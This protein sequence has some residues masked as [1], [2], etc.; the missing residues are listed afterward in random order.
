M[1]RFWQDV[2][3]APV[4]GG[5]QVV[6]D[7]RPLRTQGGAQQV[8]PSGALAEMLAAEWRAQPEEI[9][10]HGFPLRDLTDFALDKVQ[11]E[12]AGM[13]ERLLRF[14]ETDTLCYRADPDEPLFRR[15]LDLWEPL[16]TACEARLAIRFERVSGVGHRTQ[17]AATIAALRQQLENAD[18]F[19]IAALTTLASLASSLVV[20]LAA[21]EPGADA[22]ALFAASNAEEDWQAEQWGWDYEAERV[23]ELRLAAFRMAV[24]FADAARVRTSLA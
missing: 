1:K 22:D 23:R 4:H 8:V 6:L 11:A 5:W 19:T 17:P 15:Q 21:L 10:P 7:G 14:A 13:V 2:A 18:V 12:H 3:V 9:D 24:G 20:A 16:L